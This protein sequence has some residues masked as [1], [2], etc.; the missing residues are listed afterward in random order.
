MRL[1]T[2]MYHA[3]APAATRDRY[4]LCRLTFQGHL[5]ALRGAALGSPWAPGD[6]EPPSG[7]ALTFDDGHP[8]WIFAAE[9][10]AETGW[11]AAFFVVTCAIGRAGEL[12]K[13]DLRRLRAL[14][15]VVGTHTVDHPALSTLPPAEI[16]RQWR[17]SKAFLEDVLGE[18]VTAGAAPG[19]AYS[20]AVARAAAEA[21]LAHVFT[22][23]PVSRAWREEGCQ[24]YGRYAVRNGLSA[25]T[26]AALA[27]GLPLATL[28]QR[29]SWRLKALARRAL[30]SAYSAARRLTARA[31]LR[32]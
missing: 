28:P 23:E 26:A 10:L 32:G 13:A 22:S 8:G 1:N 3:I 24:V 14:G 17:D 19:G 15:Q 5:E 16:L 18:P 30:P 4:A 27:R 25:R 6:P 12:S 9:R 2:L 31:A 7:F 11:R 20:P 29:S 21:G